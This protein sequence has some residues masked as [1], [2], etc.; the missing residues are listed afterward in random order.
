M[1]DH[2]GPTASFAMGITEG[3]ATLDSIRAVLSSG[4]LPKNTHTKY[5]MWGYS[6]G[7]VASEW[8]SELQEQY[9]PEL[10]FS[11][12][13]IGGCVP[14]ITETRNNLTGTAYAGLFPGAYLG[15]TSQDEE[16]REFLVSRLKTSGPYNATAFLADVNLTVTQAFATYA[17]QDIYSYFVNGRADLENPILTQ[18]ADRNWYQGYHG[19]PLMPTFVYKAIGDEFSTVNSTDALVERWCGIGVDV[20]YQRNTVGTHITEITNGRLRALEWLGHVFEGTATVGGCS[21][22]NVTVNVTSSAS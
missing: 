18:I 2:E 12:M 17:G 11:G 1:P 20:E 8:A 9:A 14:N 21:V 22:K 7:S 16:A 19:V 6:G 10:S 3:H 5:A 4:L 13:A 15:L